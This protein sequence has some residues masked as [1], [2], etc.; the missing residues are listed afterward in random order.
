MDQAKTIS[1]PKD[2]AVRA[3]FAAQSFM[4]TLCAELVEVGNGRTRIIY[5]R[6]E[7]LCQQHGF[8]HAGVATSVADSACGYAALSMAPAGA[9]V[10]TI[11]FKTNFLRPASGDAFEARGRVVKP[12]AQIMACEAEVWETEPQNRLIATMSATMFVQKPDAP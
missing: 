3:S 9:D 11:E 2:A 8:L 1:S 12:G 4:A 10:L 6:R 7:D 5:R